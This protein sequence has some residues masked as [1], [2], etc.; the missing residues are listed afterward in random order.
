MLA[1]DR[2]NLTDKKIL[3][4]YKAQ[5][6]IEA[7]FK[8]MKNTAQVAPIF[9]KKPRRIAALGFVFL[10]ALLVNNL[11]QREIRKSFREAEETMPGDNN[12]PTAKPTTQVVFHIFQGI[13]CLSVSQAFSVVFNFEPIHEKVLSFFGLDEYVYFGQNLKN[14]AFPSGGSEIQVTRVCK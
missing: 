12:V 14:V 11:I 3:E 7:G 1:T 9:L 4:N 5:Y 10:L 13:S 2:F 8:W 6:K